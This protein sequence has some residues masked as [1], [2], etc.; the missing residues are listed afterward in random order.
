MPDRRPGRP[1]EFGDRITKAVRIDPELNERLKHEARERGVSV[2][3][4]IDKALRDYLDRL[5][6][7]EEVL[8]VS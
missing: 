8:R 4:L 1:T 5:L 6:P 3:L 2:N 7:I